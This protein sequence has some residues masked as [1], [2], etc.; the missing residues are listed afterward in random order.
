M[1]LMGPHTPAAIVSRY[2]IRKA[3]KVPRRRITAPAGSSIDKLITQVIVR[4]LCLGLGY[5][6]FVMVF[7][8]LFGRGRR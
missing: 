6:L 2:R 5:A 7:T 8:I 4:V 3:A 1:V